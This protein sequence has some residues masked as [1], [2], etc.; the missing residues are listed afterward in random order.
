MDLTAYATKIYI[1]EFSSKIKADEVY[2][3]KLKESGKAEII[4]NAKAKKI[5]GREMVKTLVYE[6]AAGGK[7]RRLEVG[8]VF[9]EIG[10][11]PATAFLQELVEFNEKNEIKIDPWTC[12]TKTPGLFAAGDVTDVKYKQVSV[13]VGEGTKAALSAHNYLTA[14]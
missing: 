7:E 10:S 13:A 3:V 5:E 4:L 2:Q 1:L 8:G 14:L 6:D 9:I 12:A 11:M